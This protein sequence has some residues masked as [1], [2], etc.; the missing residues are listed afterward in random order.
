MRQ[1]FEGC[2]AARVFAASLRREHR[3]GPAQPAPCPGV[4]LFA[5]LVLDK[6]KKGSRASARNLNSIEIPHQNA[7]PNHEQA[8]HL[9]YVSGDVGLRAKR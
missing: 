6:Q 5:S 2:A 7:Q 1:M 3:S 9:L 8:T 4:V